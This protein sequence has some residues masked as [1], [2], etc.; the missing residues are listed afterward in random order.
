[1]QQFL[2]A[3]KKESRD[4][5]GYQHLCHCEDGDAPD[6]L[7]VRNEKKPVQFGRYHDQEGKDKQR[8]EEIGV[9]TARILLNGRKIPRK[10]TKV[11]R[12]DLFYGFA[13]LSDQGI[14]GRLK[15]ARA[16]AHQA[17]GARISEHLL[18]RA[19]AFFSSITRRT[20]FLQL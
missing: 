10:V 12:T 15:T 4:K 5:S 11:A 6:Y 9:L 3:D 19:S 16:F 18:I 17:Y 14:E 13:G 1:M 7:A 8:E 20:S 2:F